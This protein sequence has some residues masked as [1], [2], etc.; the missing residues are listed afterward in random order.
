MEAL[1]RTSPSWAIAV[2]RIVL[3]ALFF[4][5]GAQKVFGWYGGYGLKA[6]TGYFVS[7][8]IPKPIA[9][10]VSFFELL[11]GLGLFFGFLTRPSALAVICV[12]IGAIAKVHA[13]HGLFI[14]WELAPGRGHGYEANLAY[15]A[16]A[17]ACLIAGGG[18]LSVDGLL[19]RSLG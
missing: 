5:H 17:V 12:Q 9:L 1:L 13:Q 14:N 6:T 4:A 16:M 3:G 18:S 11:G 8:G 10:M 7:T 19:T 2:V 15:I